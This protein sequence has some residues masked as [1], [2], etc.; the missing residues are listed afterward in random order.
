MASAVPEQQDRG[1]EM[2]I[3]AEEKYLTQKFNFVSNPLAVSFSNRY[4]RWR[5]RY[6]IHKAFKRSLCKIDKKQIEVLDIA[7][8]EGYLIFELKKLFDGKRDIHFTGI[9]IDSS[10]VE[11]AKKRK[12]LSR[13][14]NCT[15]EIMDAN[16]ITYEDLPFVLLNYNSFFLSLYFS[17]TT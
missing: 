7:C 5:H 15:F 4:T 1:Y 10:P 3:N 8:N 14:K 2:E 11:F 17:T 9:D 12:E 6:G 16:N 13:S